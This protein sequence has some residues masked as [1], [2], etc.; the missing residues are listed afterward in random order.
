VSI[1]T[2]TYSDVSNWVNDALL[3]KWA[4]IRAARELVNR[5]VEVLRSEGRVGSSLQAVVQIGVPADQRE[6]LDALRSL[7]DELKFVL[8]TSNASL[9]EAPDLKATVSA[10]AATKCERCWH[11]RD[12]VGHD[13]AH[14]TLCGRCTSNLFGTGEA[15]K[16]A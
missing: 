2:E 11:Y 7:G 6:L 14:A 8:I 5:Q 10:S 3:A 13:P 9:T 16:V 15:R 1:F 4:R 12:D